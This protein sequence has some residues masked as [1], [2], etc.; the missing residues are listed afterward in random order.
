MQDTLAPL[1]IEG[2]FLL[3][4]MFR[5]RWE[6]WKALAPETRRAVAEEAAAALGEMEKRPGGAS[7][8]AAILGHKADLML[9][10][11]RPT[12]DDLQQAELDVSRLGLSGQL[13]P[14]GSYVSVVELGLYEMT[15]KIHEELEGKGLKPNTPEFDTLLEQELSRQRE[16]LRG[17]LDPVFPPRRY[18]CFY[19]MNKKRGEIK[20]WY[21]E[22]VRRRAAMMR[23]HGLIGRRY[24]ERVTQIISGSIGYDDW[25]WGVDLFADDPLVFKKLVYEMRFDEASSWFG[26]FGSFWVGLQ[27]HASDLPRYLEGRTPGFGPRPS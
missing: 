17:R 18:V 22:P 10:H 20:N 11:F 21:A 26:E 9:I 12:L 23:E 16:R 1:T 24:G 19:P 2:H 5:V 14:A 7:A 13:E 8:A 15:L 3:H 4:Q 6:S 25:E 27:F